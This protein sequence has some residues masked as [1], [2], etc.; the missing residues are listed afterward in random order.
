MR[1]V[2][3]MVVAVVFEV[4]VDVVG[5]VPEAVAVETQEEEGKRCSSVNHV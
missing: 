3:E 5:A 2:D 4:V 1:V